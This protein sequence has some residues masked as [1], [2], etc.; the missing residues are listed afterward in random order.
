MYAMD[1]RI[2]DCNVSGTRKKAPISPTKNRFSNI[3]SYV[4]QQYNVALSIDFRA[5]VRKTVD[6]TNRRFRD[7][8]KLRK[9][10]REYNENIEFGNNDHF[11]VNEDSN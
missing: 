4:A 9:Y 6:D 2:R 11:D 8:L 1:E 5:L 7:D 3:C 10:R